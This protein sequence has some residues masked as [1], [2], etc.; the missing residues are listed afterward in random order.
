MTI[1]FPGPVVVE[2]VFDV[3][4][5]EHKMRLNCQSPITPVPGQ[6]LSTID[7][8]QRNSGTL[9]ILDAIDDLMVLLQPLFSTNMSCSLVNVYVVPD[10]SEIHNYIN[11]ATL[12]YLGSQATTYQAGGSLSFSFHTQESGAFLIRLMEP[13]IESFGRIT[14]A[15][16]TA[17]QQALVDYIDSGSSWVLARDTSY[18]FG[19]IRATGNLNRDAMNSRYDIG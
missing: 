3:A 6:A 5:I 17:A 8:V 4:G 16:L 12:A 7:V 14:Y 1:N 10:Q 18:P 13:V 19:F 11:S 9:N 15:N 2:L